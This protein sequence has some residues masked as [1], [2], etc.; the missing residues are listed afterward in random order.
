MLSQGL[1]ESAA[2]AVGL[3]I[4]VGEEELLA[5]RVQV[6]RQH[7]ER[8]GGVALLPVQL[9]VLRPGHQH[10]GQLAGAG[11]ALVRGPVRWR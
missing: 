10:G 2:D 8:L 3:L 6:S 11:K 1:L 4:G 9:V 5:V 7:G